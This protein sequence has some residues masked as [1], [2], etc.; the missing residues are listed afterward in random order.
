ML[1]EFRFPVPANAIF[2]PINLM[3]DFDALAIY[4]TEARAVRSDIGFISHEHDVVEIVQEVDDIVDTVFRCPLGIRIALIRD[5]RDEA[6]KGICRREGLHSEVHLL[7]SRGRTR[8]C[9]WET[10]KLI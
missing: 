1:H 3:G 10:R 7:E 8:P 5:I 2:D 6:Y 4:K 9:L